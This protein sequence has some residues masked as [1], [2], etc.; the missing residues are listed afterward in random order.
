MTTITQHLSTMDLK[1]GQAPHFEGLFYSESSKLSLLPS[2]TSI[3]EDLA[4]ATCPV[5]FLAWAQARQL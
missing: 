1:L 4:S 2:I 5:F 3:N